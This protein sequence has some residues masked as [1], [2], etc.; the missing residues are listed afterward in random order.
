MTNLIGKTIVAV[1]GFRHDKRVKRVD[2]QYIMFDD[3]ET[4]IELEDQ[5]Y[6]AYH[7]CS[8]SAKQIIVYHDKD[9]WERI[10]NDP[11][12]FGDATENEV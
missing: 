4:F 1:K 8:A 10:M 9:R 6:H 12:S 5:D 3:H 2:P 11:D 7:D